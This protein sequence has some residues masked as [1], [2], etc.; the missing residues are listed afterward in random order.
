MDTRKHWAIG[1]ALTALVV[2][3]VAIAWNGVPGTDPS[4]S[5]PASD[6]TP[7]ATAADAP[8]QAPDVVDVP[9]PPATPRD[10]TPAASGASSTPARRTSAASTDDPPQTDTNETV[11]DP[12][13]VYERETAQV[14][15]RGAI[16]IEAAAAKIVTAL[17]DG[18]ATAL[19]LLLAPD[20]GSQQ[21]Y[22]DSLVARYPSILSSTPG[23]NVDVY[24]QGQATVYVAYAIV[25][26]EDAEIV[27][28]HTI[29]IPL[30]YVDGEWYLT[31]LADTD[32]ELVFVQAVK[33]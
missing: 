23:A 19:G 27:S 15:T 14:V 24:A 25:R 30:R 29:A 8:A 13:A 11:P 26:W 5:P 3:G 1:I 9:T 32:G 17:M 20:E 2:L 6:G 12:W 4:D 10:L 18:D 28:E 31:S 21:P 33:L 22:A 7:P 16:E